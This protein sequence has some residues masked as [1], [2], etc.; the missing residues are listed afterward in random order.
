[1][2][3]YIVHHRFWDDAE[4]LEVF[5]SRASA[6][7]FIADIVSDEYPLDTLFILEKELR[8]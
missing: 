8:P 7:N 1:M 4:I 5:S 2:K 3:V 6:D